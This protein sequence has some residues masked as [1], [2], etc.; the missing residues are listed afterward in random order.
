M[1]LPALYA[2]ARVATAVGD[3]WSAHL[4]APLAPVIGGTVDRNP[5]CLR[6]VYQGRNVCVF[7]S[8]RQSVG[9]GDS[10]T[11]INAFI[12]RVTDLPGKHDWQIRF[13]L[14]GMFG[15][16]PKCLFIEAHDEAVAK[17]L[18]RSGVVAEVEAVSA[19]TTDYVTVA[20][21]SRRQTLTYT[22]DASPQ[23]ISSRDKFTKQLALAARLSQINERVNSV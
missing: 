1:L 16:G 17:R 2:A 15:Q 8:P 10:A 21:E 5:P 6:G 22:D 13:R 7:F 20:Y 12:I 14:T 23:R 3:M 19:P 9:S 18:N 4:L 11:W